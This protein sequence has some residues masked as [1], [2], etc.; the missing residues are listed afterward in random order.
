[1]STIP[2]LSAI[3]ISFNGMRFL[4]DCLRTLKEDLSAI[5]HEIIV[6]DNGSGDGSSEFVREQFPGVRL[7]ENGRNLG[8][9]AAVNI[10][11]RAARGEF[12]YILNQDLRF[13]KGG[14]E[15]LLRRLKA[16][17]TIGMIGPKFVGFDGIL[18]P[19]AR[20]F[21]TFRHVFYDA[22]FLSKILPQSREFGSWRMGW[23][24]HETE[25]PVDQPMGSAMLL[26]R[27]VVERVGEFD[28]SYPI[29]FNDVDYCW[30]MKQSG[31]KLLYFPDAVVEHFV[32]GSTRTM[33]VRMKWES[34]RSMY[35]YLSRH[36]H[37]YGRPGLCLCGLLLMAGVIPAAISASLRGRKVT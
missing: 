31:Y 1:M 36:T 13:R 8:F 14:T 11:L 30:R 4:P 16:D 37:W 27:G 24:D 35:R 28:E 7:I 34:H 20:A 3:I 10:G 33:P 6:V 29:F 9:A 5:P 18:Q 17:S 23:F 32:G 12:I 2:E 21:P 26:P 15:I 19:S 22:L 25:L